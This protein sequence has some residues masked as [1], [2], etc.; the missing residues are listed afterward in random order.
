MYVYMYIHMQI[1]MYTHLY[2]YS[3][4]HTHT[5]ISTYTMCI[6]HVPSHR[7]IWSAHQPLSPQC[8]AVSSEFWVQISGPP[9]LQPSAWP[10]RFRVGWVLAGEV[11]QLPRRRWPAQ[12]L[13]PF[14]LLCS[15]WR[16]RRRCLPFFMPCL[17]FSVLSSGSLGSPKCE[18][19]EM[20]V[21][22]S[23]KRA[24]ERSVCLFFETDTQRCK[25]GDRHAEIYRGRHWKI[26]VPICILTHAP[27]Y[28]YCTNI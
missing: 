2:I 18:M 12:T 5:Q 9:F 19:R 17:G 25:E 11:L 8:T 28:K 22:I 16:S 4:K 27:T 6:L 3:H 13:L 26:G 15:P 21:L 10:I 23:R 1:C 7:P 14:R 24:W 20:H